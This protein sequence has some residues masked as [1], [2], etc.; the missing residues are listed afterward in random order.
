MLAGV[1][2]CGRCGRRMYVRYGRTDR[3][4]AY[5]C[6]TL[7][8][9]YGLP[10]C[11]SVTAAEVEAWVA[12]QVLEVLQ[13]AVL[14]ASLDAAAEV[15]QRRRQV[16][17][18]WE[19]R[20]E[21]ARYEADRAARQYQACEPENRLVARTLERRWEETLQAVHQLEAEFDRF[22]RTEPRPLG[23][24]ER[25][26]IRRLAGEVPA[27]WRA[28]T[29]TPADR[30]QV[31]RL[32]VD[33]VELAADPGDDRVAVRVEWAGGAVRERTIHRAVQGYKNQQ[34]WAGLLARLATLHGRGETPKAIAATLDRD[35]FRPP[36]RAS[37]FTAGI[38]RRLLHELG[39]RPRVPRSPTA[40]A[41]LS[42]DEW[43]LHELARDLGLS[44]HTL[45]GWR[46]KGWLQ[47]R[48]V[49]GRGGPWAVWA[50]APELARLRA[51][52]ECPRSWAHRERWAELRVPGPRRG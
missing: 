52:R 22:T 13:P 30:R 29:T 2:W 18:H 40:A 37:R 12:E 5:V 10:L 39:L 24:V 27:L 50:D 17:R 19:Q 23:A 1:V 45:H 35:G 6:S 4:P 25:E 20:I 36:K 26:Q 16:I 7:R 51:L 32:L 34:S 3:R 44:P 11:Q 9:D 43:W 47:V 28:S 33:R 21:R 15:E 38:V 49:G 8:S 14:E 41:V 46:K 42:S 31:V 48:Q